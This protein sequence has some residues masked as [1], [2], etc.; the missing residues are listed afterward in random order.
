MDLDLEAVVAQNRT[1]S[2]TRQLPPAHE[3]KSSHVSG[4]AP[5]R[6]SY[7]SI[8][9]QVAGV[10]K[11]SAALDS[12]MKKLQESI[13][14]TQSAL[15]R[16]RDEV[17]DALMNDNDVPE[18]L[19]K[20]QLST[21]KKLGALFKRVRNLKQKQQEENNNCDDG[22]AAA[23]PSTQLDDRTM[24]I[25]EMSA[26]A[27]KVS[28]QPRCKCGEITILKDNTQR[29]FNYCIKCGFHSYADGNLTTFQFT[30]NSN[31]NNVD[32]SNYSA[33]GY[34]A[35][36]NN[37]AVTNH[38]SH[39]QN[40][41]SSNVSMGLHQKMEQ[42]NIVLRDTFGHNCFRPNQE[43]IVKEAFTGRD[44]FVLMPTG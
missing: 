13:S 43:R 24:M 37:Y 36:S 21:Q 44:V 9:R 23:Y 26:A 7:P 15:R 30:S 39:H 35:T 19:A 32:S 29:P 25:Q 18:A 5:A 16:I 41:S 14:A 22:P 27:E 10:S 17:D 34:P 1:T 11:S 12:Q 31:G 8:D 33:T 28:F 42:M 6:E 2:S 3:N 40:T 20:S 38:Y 4:P